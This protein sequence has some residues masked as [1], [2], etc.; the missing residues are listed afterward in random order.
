MISDVNAFTNLGT[1]GKMTMR[2]R[3]CENKN[4]TNL[5]ADADNPNDVESP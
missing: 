4:T 2:A 5:S 3:R 1:A